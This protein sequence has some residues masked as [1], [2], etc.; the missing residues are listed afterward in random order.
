MIYDPFRY[1]GVGRPANDASPACAPAIA[2][3]DD[4]AARL[5]PVYDR[6]AQELFASAGATIDLD[7]VLAV[8]ADALD[9][10]ERC[11]ESPLEGR[12][13]VIAMDAHDHDDMKC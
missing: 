11:A 8:H 5:F 13:M 10:V 7:V 1:A 3:P 9:C 2:V 6:A 4:A 12:P